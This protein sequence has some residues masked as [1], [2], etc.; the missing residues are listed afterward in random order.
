MEQV[1]ANEALKTSETGPEVNEDIAKGNSPR[2]PATEIQTWIPVLILCQSLRDT[3][4]SFRHQIDL[5]ENHTI[6]G[7]KDHVRKGHE[8]E[9]DSSPILF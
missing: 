8:N 1:D 6:T 5:F 4:Q 9:S 2:A 7:H 3:Q